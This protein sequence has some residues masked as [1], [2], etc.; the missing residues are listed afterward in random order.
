MPADDRPA[1]FQGTAQAF[2]DSLA[3]LGLLLLM[4]AILVIYMI[5]GVLYES[6]IHPITILS[7]LPSAGVGALLTLLIFHQDLNLYSFR[8]HHHADR[9]REEERHH[10]DRLRARRGAQRGQEPRGSD[11]PGL[12]CVRF[13][14][15]MMTTMAALMG[16]LP[17]ALGVGAGAESRRGWVWRSSAG[18]CSRSW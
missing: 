9:H 15:I 18:C 14:P 17:I 4:L 5:L 1:R 13:R 16:T 6:F 2:Q 11:L 12:R 7:G 3:G 10:D 8:R